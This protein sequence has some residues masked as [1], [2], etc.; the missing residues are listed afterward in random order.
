MAIDF[1]RYASNYGGRGSSGGGGGG[2]GNPLAQGMRDIGK[3]MGP[4]RERAQW[5]RDAAT[6]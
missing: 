4:Y 5:A 6:Y 3:A 1:S 2:G